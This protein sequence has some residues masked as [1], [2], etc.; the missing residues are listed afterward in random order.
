MNNDAVYTWYFVIYVGL[1]HIHK[2]T[3]EN[4]PPPKPEPISQS[5]LLI[6]NHS[7]ISSSDHLDSI[8]RKISWLVEVSTIDSLE[9][10]PSKSILTLSNL[11]SIPILIS[12]K[13]WSTSGKNV[14]TT[15]KSDLASLPIQN[16]SP[17][18]CD[19]LARNK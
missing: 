5:N 16:Y 18:C 12:P 10:L 13:S 19:T 6:L 14:C 2:I 7:F 3:Q 17:C 1:L 4:I 15:T 9:P 8:S 11:P